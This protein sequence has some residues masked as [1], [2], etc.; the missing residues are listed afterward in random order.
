MHGII[1]G[2]MPPDV[3]QASLSRTLFENLLALLGVLKNPLN[4]QKHT[5]LCVDLLFDGRISA[6]TVGPYPLG[7]LENARTDSLSSF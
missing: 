7:Y 3:R 6:F 5:I 2:N 1:M 4:F